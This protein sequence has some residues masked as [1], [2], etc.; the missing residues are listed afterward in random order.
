[1]K[2]E[3]AASE[4]PLARRGNGGDKV[5]DKVGDEVGMAGGGAAEEGPSGLRVR[6]DG[7]SWNAVPRGGSASGVQSAGEGKVKP[8]KR[9][10][11]S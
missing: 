9:L 11:R 1:M 3:S 4:G 10:A 7:Q 5:N 8:L 2:E 6:G